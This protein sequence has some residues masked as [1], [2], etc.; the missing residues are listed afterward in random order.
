MQKGRIVRK[1]IS[2]AHLCAYVISIC[3]LALAGCARKYQRQTTEQIRVPDIGKAETMELAE[4]VLAQL[5]FTIDKADADCGLIRTRPLPGAQFFEFWRGD[6]VG[7]DNTLQANL[8]TIRRT[9]ELDITQQDSKIC[10]GCNVKVQ[11]LS[12][13]E[14][15]ITSSARAYDMFSRSSPYLQRL[16]LNPEQAKAAMWTDLGTDTLLATEI[17]K[18]IEERIL[19]Q[20][21]HEPQMTESQS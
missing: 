10:I 7:P 18:R 20:T 13:P 19:R 8:H 12:L 16:I 11:R 4:D 1:Y 6:N 3:V 5:H 2:R 17:L 15:E 21:S 14:R 9:V